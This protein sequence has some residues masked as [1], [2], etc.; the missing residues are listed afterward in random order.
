MRRFCVPALVVAATL[1]S[2]APASANICDPPFAGIA[3]RGEVREP[4]LG[5]THTDMPASA[6]GK[7][8]A[9][10]KATI[11]VYFH[12]V[13]AG[14][15]SQLTDAQIAAQIDVLNRTFAGGE[16]GAKTG[17]SF[18]LAGVTRTDNAAWH[19]AGPGGNN[20]HSMKAALHQGGS[21][22]LN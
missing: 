12:V 15:I 5:Q 18:K 3:A 17:F 9:N 10:F 4:D 19:Y 11:P 16:G 1:I 20:E 7:A 6:K 21:E 14:T 22:A 2:A 13:T 8:K